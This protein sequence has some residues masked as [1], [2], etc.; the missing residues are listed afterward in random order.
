M[1]KICERLN[2]ASKVLSAVVALTVFGAVPVS[3]QAAANGFSLGL[4]GGFA[5]PSSSSSPFNS[6]NLGYYVLGTL[7]TPSLFRVFRPR[8][9]GFY[10]DWG[11]HVSSLTGN[12]LFIPVAGK[13]V[14]PY[15][16]AG[17]GAYAAPGSAVKAGWTLGAGLRLPGELRTIT[18]ESRAHVF[19]KDRP[20]D[21]SQRWRY[22]FTPIGLGI[23]F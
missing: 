11:E 1:T 18:I 4:A 19:L 10:A 6:T 23:Q 2:S 16:L 21:N 8:I 20:Q 13:R 12:L 17:A 14:A 9:D 22:L 15:I 7:E 5:R 3:A